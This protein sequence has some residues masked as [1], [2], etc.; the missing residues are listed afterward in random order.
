MLFESSDL[1]R[2]VCDEAHRMHSK[3]FERLCRDFEDATVSLI[4]Q[5]EVCLHCIEAHV[6]QLI[7]A[8]LGHQSDATA[9]LLLV[10]ED[11]GAFVTDALHRQLE[12]LTAVAAERTEDITCEALRMNA[13]HRRRCVDV[14]QYQRHA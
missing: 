5:L 14:S 7:G 12:L 13:D 2:I 8:Q 10:D 6:L 9:F 4:A 3:E 11:A 1:L